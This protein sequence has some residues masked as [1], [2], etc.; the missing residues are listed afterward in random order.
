MKMTELNAIQQEIL[1]AMNQL[2]NKAMYTEAI[3][4]KKIREN[5]KMESKKKAG[6]SINDIDK[7]LEFIE[8]NKI[9]NYCIKLN[10]ANEFLFSKET[11]SKL[12]TP[13]ARKRRLS[14]EKSMSILTS[15]DV[16]SSGKKGGK[17]GNKKRTDRKSFRTNIDLDLLD[18]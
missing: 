13:E 18:E 4:A 5:A 12:L 6:V 17:P 3:L 16:S 15:S 14:S 2:E 7:V 10:S 1:K 11:E 9:A 8:E